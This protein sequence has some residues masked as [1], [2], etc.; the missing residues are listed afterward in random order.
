MLMML[1][2]IISCRYECIA[3]EQLVDQGARYDIVVASE[4]I[5]H[6]LQPDQFVRTLA[7]LLAGDDRIVDRD[8]QHADVEQSSLGS[9]RDDEMNSTSGQSGDLEQ[10]SSSRKQQNGVL[11]C[12]RI[13]SSSSL[14]VL[15]TINRTPES[16]AVAIIGAEYITGIVPRGTHQWERFIT[17]TELA[18][19][20]TQVRPFL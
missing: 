14:L 10:F 19:M 17:P 1:M 13:S 12:S 4:V 9:F 2:C 7:T 11:Q 18:M 20:A 6:V 5:E 8:R 15:S 3:A 16:Y